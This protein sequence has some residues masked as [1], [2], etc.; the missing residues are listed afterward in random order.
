MEVWKDIKGF[1][2]KYQVSTL[3]EI[4]ALPKVV[5]YKD[6]RTYKYPEKILTGK[7]S[8]G[9]YLHL[10]LFISTGQPK[11]VD[12]HRIVAETFIPNPDKKREVNHINGNKQDNRVENLEWVTSK[13]NKKHGF[14]NGLYVNKNQG[15]GKQKQIQNG[16]YQPR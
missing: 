16:T 12:V 3:G 7:Q 14:L 5:R 1:E 10:N 9:K 2:G 15:K 6:G 13:E 4:K 11:T 8:P